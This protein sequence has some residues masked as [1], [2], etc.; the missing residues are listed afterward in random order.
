MTDSGSIAN[1]N[2]ITLTETGN[3][4]TD[5][6]DISVSANQKIPIHF[7]R[8]GRFG[9]FAYGNGLTLIDSNFTTGWDYDFGSPGSV[10]T[11]AVSFSFFVKVPSRFQNPSNS[12]NNQTFNIIEF[13]RD[14]EGTPPLDSSLYGSISLT[15]SQTTNTKLTYKKSSNSINDAYGVHRAFDF[16]LFSICF[17]RWE[18]EKWKYERWTSDD[19]RS[20]VRK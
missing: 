13:R 5:S 15:V 8:D 12:L 7:V 6:P 16:G 11:T 14:I 1:P 3:F 4:Y 9:N 17:G 20:R 19:E 2:S 10:S 18:K